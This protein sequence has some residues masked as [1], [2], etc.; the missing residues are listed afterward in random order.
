MFTTIWRRFTGAALAALTIGVGAP[1]ASAT[2][3]AENAARITKVAAPITKVAAPITKVMVIAEEN[4]TYGEIVGNSEAPYL[5]R[6]A[7]TYGSAARMV[8]NYPARCPSLA[9]YLL[10][11]SGTTDGICDDRGPAHHRLNVPNIFAQLDAKHRPWR[12]YAESLPAP[13]A[14]KNSPNGVFLVR[15]TAVPYYTSEARACAIGQVELGT[16]ARGALHDAAHAGRLPTYSFVTPNTCH[17][18]HGAPS[19]PTRRIVNGDRWLATWIPQILA[20]PDYRAGRL[21]VIITWDEGSVRDNHIP[22]LVISPGTH[23]MVAHRPYDHCS[24]LRTTEDLLGLAAIGCARTATA[25]TA[26][27][28]L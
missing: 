9:G 2:P 8:A 3:R 11:T 4:G 10:M 16:P 25:M 23:G 21:A 27:F 19:C 5:S 12:N 22:V 18:M 14:R 20:G 17:D 28:R 13:C 1:A 15:H 26:D 24:T 7:R 6:L